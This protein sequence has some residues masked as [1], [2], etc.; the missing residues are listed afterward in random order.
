MYYYV[1]FGILRISVSESAKLLTGLVRYS[2]LFLSVVTTRTQ[3]LVWPR[4][5]GRRM[6]GLFGSN[7]NN[8]WIFLIVL[9]TGTARALKKK[10]YICNISLFFIYWNVETTK[11]LGSNP[12]PGSGMTK[13]HHFCS[14]LNPWHLYIYTSLSTIFEKMHGLPA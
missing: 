12:K 4:P 1:F 8:S 3:F 14:I 6:S 11:K 2:P 9:G 10:P 13:C 7:D 5:R